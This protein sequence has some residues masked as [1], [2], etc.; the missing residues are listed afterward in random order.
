MSDLGPMPAGVAQANVNHQLVAMLQRALDDAKAGKIIGGAAI[1]IEADNILNARTPITCPP[2]CTTTII[3][4]IEF[5]KEEII[6]MVR[7]MQ[8][9]GGRQILRAS[10][11]PTTRQ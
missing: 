4:S 5:L 3:A 8:R 9:G 2:S 7:Q 6:S 10:A 11:V 1:L